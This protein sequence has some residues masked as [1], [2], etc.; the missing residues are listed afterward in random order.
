[1]TKEW[2]KT[3]QMPLVAVLTSILAQ[4]I[5][6]GGDL[7]LVEITKEIIEILGKYNF[8]SYN[9]EENTLGVRKWRGQEKPQ[10]TDIG[11]CPRFT[12]LQYT[13]G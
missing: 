8:C 3:Q 5:R 9:G 13:L 10:R 12:L 11:M 4:N 6:T 7:N 1:M 2:V